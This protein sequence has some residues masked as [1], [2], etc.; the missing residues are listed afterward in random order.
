MNTVWSPGP[1]KHHSPL[2]CMHTAALQ[3]LKQEHRHSGYAEEAGTDS[4]MLQHCWQLEVLKRVIFQVE[5][6]CEL[7]SSPCI[8]G[9]GCFV[10]TCSCREI[11][12]HQLKIERYHLDTHGALCL[13]A[14]RGYYSR[15]K[16][17][18]QFSLQVKPYTKKYIKEWNGYPKVI[19]LLRLCY[20]CLQ[21]GYRTLSCK[22][23]QRDVSTVKKKKK[24]KKIKPLI[25]SAGLKYLIYVL[26]PSTQ[27]IPNLSDEL[28][29][30][31]IF[32][33]RI[34]R[35]RKR[36]IAQVEKCA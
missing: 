11:N 19:A 25:L 20:S 24:S 12:G 4:G 8:C 23:F 26:L 35:R 22:T 30:F 7:Y 33:S 16:S 34:R 10:P 3:S 28:H 2:G 13:A 29:P 1:I 9:Q 18:S 31:T 36:I 17:N 14:P 5:N 21:K 15:Q 32:C 27:N 6:T